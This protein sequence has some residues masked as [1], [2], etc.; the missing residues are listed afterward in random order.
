MLYQNMDE[1][2]C[3]T[4]ITG[5]IIAKLMREA[6]GPHAILRSLEAKRIGIGQGIIS[7]LIQLKLEWE[8]SEENHLPATVIA[9]LSNAE[10]SVQRRSE[11]STVR[12]PEEFE[13]KEAFQARKINGFHDAECE[14]YRM[15]GK[16]PPLAIPKFFT[17]SSLEGYDKLGIIILEDLSEKATV[18]PSFVDGMTYPQI[19]ATVK[20]LAHMHAWSL[21]TSID[22]RSKILSIEEKENEQKDRLKNLAARYSKTKEKYP[23]YFGSIDVEKLFEMTCFE[24][25]ITIY[26]EHQEFMDDVLV[27][28]D[29][30]A[31]NI[32]FE[33]NMDGTAGDR[34]VALID[35]Q[36]VQKGSPAYD[37][38]RLFCI[39]VPF[40]VRR[41][42]YD[43]VVRRYYDEVKSIAGDK[44]KAT[45]EQFRLLT[46][47]QFAYCAISAVSSVFELCEVMVK[48]EGE[49]KLKDEQKTV[50]LLKANYDDAMSILGL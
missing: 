27:H 28:A 32:M 8:P 25:L 16:S 47:R 10:E 19:L 41:N 49:Q 30:H 44:F 48:S 22:W 2:I 18:I 31:M 40:E 6:L 42:H 29:L 46:D 14:V 5:H 23:E 4:P 34:L 33:K 15:F 11:K 12:S 7:S 3:E 50:E 1:K 43:D 20:E 21:T 37:V 24:S 38:G 35:F 45:F 39:S 36:A 17:A 9:K 26:N 13:K